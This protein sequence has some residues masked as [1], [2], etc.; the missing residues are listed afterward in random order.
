EAAKGL[1]ELAKK[2]PL[3]ATALSGVGGAAAGPEK[4]LHAI[5][6]SPQ[7]AAALGAIGVVGPTGMGLISGAVGAKIADELTNKGDPTAARSGKLKGEA[8]WTMNGFQNVLQGDGS[9]DFRDEKTIEAM[10][11]SPRIR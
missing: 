8:K 9:G 3:I 4:I 5:K 10:F 2:H 1:L 6:H 7:I 11:A